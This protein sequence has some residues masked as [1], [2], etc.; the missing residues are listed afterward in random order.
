MEGR[1]GC[2]KGPIS[3]A[4]CLAHRLPPPGPT[5]YTILCT[6]PPHTRRALQDLLVDKVEGWARW[7][8]GQGGW[9]ER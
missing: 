1:R 9:M 3:T 5:P 7:S 8:D 6:S 2:K 4:Q